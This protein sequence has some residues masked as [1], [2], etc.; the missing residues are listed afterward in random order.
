MADATVT[1]GLDASQLK[2]GLAKATTDVNAFASKAQGSFG[3]VG[4]G[5]RGFA[6][7]QVG[8]QLQD[9]A[10]QMQMGT[11]AATIFAQQGS[12][13]ASAFGPAGIAIGATVA[14]VGALYTAGSKS[15]EMFD[16]MI[17]NVGNLQTQADSVIQS[18]GLSEITDQTIKLAEASKQLSESSDALSTMGGAFA[19]VMGMILGGDSPQ[20]RQNKLAKAASDLEFKRQ[21]LALSALEASTQEVAIAELRAKGMNDEAD[22]AER[23][24]SLKKETAK[25]DQLPFTDKTKTKLKEDAEAISIATKAAKD[26][27]QALKD[28]DQAKKDAEKAEREKVKGDRDGDGIISKR[29]QRRLDLE[30]ER[31]MRKANSIKGFSRE[32]RGLPAFAGLAELEEMSA[33]SIYQGQESVGQR[34]RGVTSKSDPRSWSITPNLQSAFGGR[35]PDSS[36]GRT[37]AV[38]ERLLNV[39]D[40]RLTVD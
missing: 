3:K 20:E 5:G 6:M 40:Q 29:E 37:V 14:V 38:L 16:D 22:E 7:G 39:V 24:L 32:K 35:A 9:I 2:T 30:Q 27:E 17:K 28:A 21:K 23:L 33:M 10:V 25:I 11:K 4:G 1:L 18:G 36:S 13:I 15:N 34:W 26:Y 19:P 12:Q 31:A 8:M